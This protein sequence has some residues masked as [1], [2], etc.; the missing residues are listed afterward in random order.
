MRQIDRVLEQILKEPGLDDDEL[1]RRTRI[2]PRQRIQ[3]L[4]AQLAEKGE[5]IRQ[6]TERRGKRRKI[7][8]YPAEAAAGPAK[9]Q[10]L[11]PK[12]EPWERRLAA[13]EAATGADPARILDVA[14]EHLAL[15]VLQ[16][17]DVG[18]T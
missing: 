6:S 14:L 1:S 10:P 4:C 5:V 17:D 15:R 2:M 16:G 12:R 11:G 13:L 3:Q 9:P 8:N 18:L 7:C